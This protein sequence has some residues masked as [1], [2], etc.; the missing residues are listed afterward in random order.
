MVIKHPDTGTDYSAQKPE[1]RP[2]A[3]AVPRQ[4]AAAEDRPGVS[5]SR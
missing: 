5:A 1:A 2:L 4:R 3:A